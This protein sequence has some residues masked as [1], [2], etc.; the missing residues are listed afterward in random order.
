MMKATR[1]ISL[2]E[3]RNQLNSSAPIE[4]QDKKCRKHGKTLE[5]KHTLAVTKG[6]SSWGVA[7][8]VFMLTA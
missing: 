1:I 8:R 3:V 7:H 5:N 6:P 4:Q 2:K